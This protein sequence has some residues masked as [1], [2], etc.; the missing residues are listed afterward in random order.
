MRLHFLSQ[1]SKNL[2]RNPQFESHWSALCHMTNTDAR[3]AAKVSVFSWTHCYS[4]QNQNS[5]TKGEGDALWVGI[6]SPCHR[7]VWRVSQGTL[8]I[9]KFKQLITLTFDKYEEAE[10]KHTNF[11]EA[12][13][14]INLTRGKYG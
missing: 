14:F 1:E 7:G 5:F 12:I 4:G 3:E 9:M 8:D 6:S 10:E 13:A 11:Q 2:P